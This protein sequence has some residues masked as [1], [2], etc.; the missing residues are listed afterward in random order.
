MIESSPLADSVQALSSLFDKLS[1]VQICDHFYWPSTKTKPAQN[2]QMRG[3]MNFQTRWK[4]PFKQSNLLNELSG[5]AVAGAGGIEPPNG[6]IKIRC[7]TAW[8]RP[9][10]LSSERRRKPAVR[11][12]RS[13]EGVR[14]FQQARTPKF[15]SKRAC[16]LLTLYNGRLNITAGSACGTAPGRIDTLPRRPDS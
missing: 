15:R 12:R 2:F 14:L 16:P 13:I 3:K 5:L 6:G 4:F 1:D 7:L 11:H 9:I 10:W 8:L